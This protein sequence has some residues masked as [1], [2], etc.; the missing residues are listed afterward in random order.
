MKTNK[1]IIGSTIF[2]FLLCFL[3][4]FLYDWFPNPVF[5]IFFPVNESVWEHMK[6]IY[7]TVL[8]YGVIE[9]FI[10][11]K[12]NSNVNNFFITKV[13]EAL[14][15][16]PIFLI[17]YYPIFWIIG[18]NM[19]VTFIILFLSI[20]LTN[21]IFTRLLFKS[22]IKN[23]KIVSILLIIFVYALMGIL[24]YNPPRYEIFFDPQDEKY[25]IND[26]LTEKN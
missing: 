4:H 2:T 16:I 17:M 18:E 14:C 19:I 20:L 8:L 1:I 25:G 9:Y 15:N 26:Y 21:F 23:Q 10:L 5:S 7:T 13:L 11:K 12:T 3:T 24:T 22:E 6:M